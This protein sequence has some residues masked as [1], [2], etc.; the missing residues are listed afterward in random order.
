MTPEQ[1]QRLE[2]A[3]QRQAAEAAEIK[4]LAEDSFTEFLRQALSDRRGKHDE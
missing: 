4:R 3:K 2:E 1:K